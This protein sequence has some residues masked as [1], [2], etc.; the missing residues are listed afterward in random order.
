MTNSNYKVE[1]FHNKNQFLIYG[2]EQ[3]IF[4]S[5]NSTIAII[6]DGALMLGPDWD[7]SKTTLKHLYLFLDEYRY[8]ITTSNYLQEKIAQILAHSKNKKSAI[9]KLIDKGFILYN[10]EEKN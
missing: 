8:K 6:K 2:P 3:I 1:Q 5:Y 7:Y 4:Q 9:Q 10:E